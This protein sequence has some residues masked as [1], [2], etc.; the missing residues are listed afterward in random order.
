MILP[1]SSFH[2][3]KDIPAILLESLTI[4]MIKDISVNCLSLHPKPGLILLNIRLSTTVSSSLYSYPRRYLVSPSNVQLKRCSV[5][6][7]CK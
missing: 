5:P 6:L 2:L 3:V 1:E 7:S 4:P